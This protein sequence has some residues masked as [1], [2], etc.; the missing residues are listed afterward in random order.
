M[1]FCFNWVLKFLVHLLVAGKSVNLNCLGVR[2]A[3]VTKLLRRR[4][5]KG[6]EKVGLYLSTLS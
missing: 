6:H 1:A 5:G 4:L 3:T 2:H